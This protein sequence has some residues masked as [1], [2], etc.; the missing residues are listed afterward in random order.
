M[1]QSSRFIKLFIPIIIA[2][3]LSATVSFL[4][5]VKNVLLIMI[6]A[7]FTGVIGALIGV[8]WAFGDWIK[9]I[10]APTKGS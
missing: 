9:E 6:I 3:C 5:E 10:F 2:M 7:M 4:F 1:T 8:W